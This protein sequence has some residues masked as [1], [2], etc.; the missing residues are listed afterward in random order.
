[1]EILNIKVEDVL[2]V[3]HKVLWPDKPIEFC[4]VKGDDEALHYGAFIE[5]ELV[6]VASIYIAD[7]SARLRKFATLTNYQGKGIGSTL[8]RHILQDLNDRKMIRFWCDARESS[9]ELFKKF[10]M[11]QYSVRF[12]KEDIPYFKMAVSLSK[13]AQR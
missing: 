12:Y 10:G 9:V 6:S 2:P 7:K 4:Q 5:K 13:E 8:I 11:G 1:M 3:R